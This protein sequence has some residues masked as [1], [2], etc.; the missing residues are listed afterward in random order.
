M[1]CSAFLYVEKVCFFLQSYGWKNILGRDL[2]F[3]GV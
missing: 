1:V 3:M 2:S